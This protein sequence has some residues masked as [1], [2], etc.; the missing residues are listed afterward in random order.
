M[1]KDVDKL[2]FKTEPKKAKPVKSL[3]EEELEKVDKEE[4]EMSKESVKVTDCF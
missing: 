4:S 3:T 2:I 1:L